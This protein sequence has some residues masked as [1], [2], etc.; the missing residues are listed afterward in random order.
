MSLKLMIYII[1]VD[2]VMDS[3]S[4]ISDKQAYGV[5]KNSDHH[6]VRRLNLRL[7][8]YYS[9]HLGVSIQYIPLKVLG[10]EEQSLAI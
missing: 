5:W 2:A 1:Q 8:N 4:F 3:Y 9:S 6:Y 7:G 10:R